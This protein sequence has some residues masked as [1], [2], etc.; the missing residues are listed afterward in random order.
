MERTGGTLI[1]PK[2]HQTFSS[3][4]LLVKIEFINVVMQKEREH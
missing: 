4:L 2:S 3:Q 1:S